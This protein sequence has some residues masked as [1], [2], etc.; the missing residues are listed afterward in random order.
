MRKEIFCCP[1]C[2]SSE[3]RIKSIEVVDNDILITEICTECGNHWKDYCGLY[4]LGYIQND[5]YF[6]RDGIRK[7]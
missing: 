3:P 6:D 1:L 7:E 4:I 5:I 2:K